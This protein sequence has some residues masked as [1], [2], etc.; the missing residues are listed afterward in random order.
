[1]TNGAKTIGVTAVTRALTILD[2]FGAGEAALTLG[3][4]ARR[5]RLHKTTVLRIARTMAAARYL[6]RLANGS[7]RLGPAS[8][9]LGSRY[10]MAFDAI[11]IEPALREASRLSGESASFYVREGNTRT[12]I[13]R[14]DGPQSD[15]YQVR[16]G[17]IRPL[18][19]GA[20]GKVLLAYSGEPGDIYERIRRVGYHTSFGE[21]DARLASIAF[22]VFGITRSLI[23]CVSLFGPL[24]R[25]DRAALARYSGILRKAAGQLTFEL[26][27]SHSTNAGRTAR[28]G[29]SELL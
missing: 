6:V 10:N 3:E 14:V 8:G 1:M 12:C 19:K 5:S 27:I 20:P 17:E 28:K 22:P 16:I 21:R 26:S 13:A 15:I 11:I 24:A 25:F 29:L 18:D 23:G 7:W 4:I 2:A 9:W